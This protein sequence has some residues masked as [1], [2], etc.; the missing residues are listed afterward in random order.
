MRKIKIGAKY[1]HYK[2]EEYVILHLGR[3]SDTL[4]DVVVYQGQYSS[5]QFGENPIWVR[6]LSEFVEEVEVKGVLIKRFECVEENE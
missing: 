1:R 2:G 6:P 5:D 3:D 4:D